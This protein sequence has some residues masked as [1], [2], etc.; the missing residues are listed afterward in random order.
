MCSRPSRKLSFLSSWGKIQWYKIWDGEPRA[1][2]GLP[3]GLHPATPH[4]HTQTCSQEEQAGAAA[5]SRSPKSRREASWRKG[6]RETGGR[7]PSIL[8]SGQELNP[9]RPHLCPHLL[10]ATEKTADYQEP[11]MEDP[12]PLPHLPMPGSQLALLD[13]L[14]PAP[15]LGYGRGLSAFTNENHAS[16]SEGWPQ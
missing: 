2:S 16:N 15:P 3:R 4:S 11:G 5:S 14:P 8:G 12:A 6:H 1:T 7:T 10:R 9:S 13:P